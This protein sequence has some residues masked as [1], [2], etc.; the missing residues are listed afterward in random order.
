MEKAFC[1]VIFRC[2]ACFL[3]VMLLV[4]ASAEL[5]SMP[6]VGSAASGEY[7]D[8]DGVCERIATGFYGFEEQICISD[9]N[10]LPEQIGDI[11]ISVIKNDPYL[12]FVDNHLSYSYHKNGYVIDLTPRYN[13]TRDEADEQ[14]EYCRAEVARITSEISATY[15]ELERALLAHDY[16]CKNY[17]Y[18]LSLENDNMYKFFRNGSGNCQGYTWA[19]MAI[20]RELGIESEY[21]AS[22]TVN[23][24]WNLVKLD[25]EWYHCDVTWD[26][27]IGEENNSTSIS[28]KHFLCSD[29]K[30]EEQGH[31]DWY[32]ANGTVCTS[33]KYDT[34]DFDKVVHS[35][36]LTGDVDHNGAVELIDLLICKEMYV[37]GTEHYGICLD[38]MDADGD[39]A[40]SC[41][42]LSRIRMGMLG[43]Q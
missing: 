13:V 5:F 9:Y 7:S 28:R 3:C 24:I 11:F 16:L 29:K 1:R 41:G 38:C 26:D 35:W 14:A 19:Y 43:S 8:I 37:N 18:D 25:G 34:F 42:D 20:L 40:V 22:D 6:L 12:F 32:S 36:A 2:M 33:E 23:H 27:P 15:G 21:A 10:V 31:S 4:L 39:G 17:H 30:T